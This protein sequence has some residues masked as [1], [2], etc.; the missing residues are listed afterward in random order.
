[1]TD[2]TTPETKEVTAPQE[3][4]L[5]RAE[6]I[7]AKVRL[8]TI[9]TKLYYDP[10][11]MFYAHLFFQIDR[12]IDTKCPTMGVGLKGGN[13]QL[14]YNPRFMSTLDDESI[15][16]VLKH[17]C[18]TGDMKID[19][20][21]GKMRIKDIVDKKLTIKVK[22]INEQTGKEEYKRVTNWS[23]KYIK[24]HDHKRWVTVKYTTNNHLYKTL[25]CTNDHLL[26]YVENPL[27]TEIKYAKA[28]DCVGKYT[29]RSVN[30]DRKLNKERAM[31]NQ[32]QLEVIYGLLLGDSGIG[33]D[34]ALKSTGSL[35]HGEYTNYKKS[36]LGGHI[37]NECSGYTGEKSILQL[38]HGV[39]AFSKYLQDIIYR[40]KK[41]VDFLLDN[42]TEKSLAFW[43]MDDGSWDGYGTSF[44]HTEGFSNED[45][46]KIVKCLA[47]KFGIESEVN[48]R[49]GRELFRIKMKKEGTEKLHSL[50]AKYVHPSMQY[51]IPESLRSEYSASNIDIQKLGYSV[52]KVKFVNDIPYKKSALYD[53]TVEDNHN[54]FANDNLVHNCFH[55]IN[56]HL[57]RGEGAKNKDMTLHRLENIAMDN[58]IN[59]YLNKSIIEKIGG[60][61]METFTKVLKNLPD[62][63]KVK[64]KMPYEYYLELLKQEKDAREK[65]GEGD[66]F[67]EMLEGMEMD[68]HGQFG[69]M[70]ALDRAMLEEKIKQAASKA[71]AAGAGNMPSEV[72]ELLKLLKKP[73]ITWKR[74]L[75]QFIGA[76]LKSESRSTR[77]RRNRYYGI[78]VAGKKKDHVARILVLVDESGSMHWN[79]RR[80]NAL[81]EM[82]G[83]WKANPS[84]ELDICEFSMGTTQVFKYKGKDE[85]K[86]SGGGG[87][88]PNES[89]KYAQDN[90]YDG[91]I[92]LSDCEFF[93]E[94]Y[95]PNINTLF[96]CVD[97]PSYKS[98]FG[99]TIHIPSGESV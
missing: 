80:D 82:Y 86:A 9:L 31:Y 38:N 3:V 6:C 90:K 14:V 55:I 70:D 35:K 94:I 22:S 56:Q 16:E 41:T 57:H 54:F 64:E 46:D 63:F 2:Q 89:L 52:N 58:S 98:P 51:K 12:R 81:S 42:I 23:K 66:K 84:T 48:K 28:E 36:V 75:K 24:D 4:P 20:E 87:T 8:E 91:V 33:P 99:R 1:M 17:E 68:D 73:K 92:V 72:E 34:G 71:K 95:N 18:I 93:S 10:K 96:V 85:Y 13:L 30:E 15:T 59:Q 88:C 19:T 67:Q 69:E 47:E 26:A 11:D 53:I 32:D 21:N 77:S 45:Q 78:K 37:R 40:P 62:T 43:Y 29:L 25:H 39:T 5:T 97:N 83:I 50:I 79:N 60:V 76:G 65:N 49:S 7:E 61:T 27:S 74:E 44:L